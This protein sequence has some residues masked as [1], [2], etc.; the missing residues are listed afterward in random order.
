MSLKTEPNPVCFKKKKRKKDRKFTSPSGFLLQTTSLP[1][2]TPQHRRGRPWGPLPVCGRLTHRPRDGPRSPTLPPSL[3]PPCV[4][5]TMFKWKIECSTQKHFSNDILR[6]NEITENQGGKFKWCDPQATFSFFF[7]KNSLKGLFTRVR[8]EHI[9]GDLGPRDHLG[10]SDTYANVKNSHDATY[11]HTL[12][13]NSLLPEMQMDPEV[14]LR[15]VKPSHSPLASQVNSLP[16]P[17]IPN[18]S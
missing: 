11:A 17:E 4:G 6:K 15:F 12:T 13:P 9:W 8:G 3:G 14:P 10:G 2:G 1:L 5:F 7:S 16:L 18:V